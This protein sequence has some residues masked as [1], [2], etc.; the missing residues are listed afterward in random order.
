MTLTVGAGWM[1]EEFDLL[2]QSFE[3]RGKRLNE[4]IPAL[5]ALVARA[6]GCRGAASTTRCRS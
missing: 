6:A 2:G 1:R 4:M 3:N 5:R